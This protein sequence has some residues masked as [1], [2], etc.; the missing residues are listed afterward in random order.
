MRKSNI[1]SRRISNPTLFQKR[2]LNISPLSPK[3]PVRAPGASSVTM[4]ARNTRAKAAP[5]KT[6]GT[7]AA[8]KGSPNTVSKKTGEPGNH[9]KSEKSMPKYDL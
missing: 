4:P 7:T 9:R 5:K 6:A 1:L 2:F 3:S 8:S